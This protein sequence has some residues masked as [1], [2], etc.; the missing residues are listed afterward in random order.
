MNLGCRQRCCRS[1]SPE[2]WMTSFDTKAGNLCKR[3]CH[4]NYRR[5]ADDQWL[6]LR[7]VK[8]VRFRMSLE[9]LKRMAA[10]TILQGRN[11]AP[12]APTKIQT[13]FCSKDY[14]L[15]ASRLAGE[16]KALWNVLW[17]ALYFNDTTFMN[18][19]IVKPWTW[20]C[21]GNMIKML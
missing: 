6:D 11:L 2:E 5:G 3:P 10:G 18:A 13:L 21:R 9:L 16:S 17:A 19:R 7:G 20:I 15:L 12:T 8:A 14:S 4:W 1:S